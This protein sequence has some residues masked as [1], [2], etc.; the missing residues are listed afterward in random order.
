MVPIVFL[1]TFCVQWFCAAMSSKG[2]VLPFSVPVHCL[3]LPL[4]LVLGRDS[5]LG[6]N[7]GRVLDETSTLRT[8]VTCVKPPTHP[9]L[10][11][12]V[13]F[14]FFNG[15]NLSPDP[16]RPCGSH[17]EIQPSH[18]FVLPMT[19]PLEGGRRLR[20]GP[21]AGRAPLHRALRSLCSQETSLHAA[22]RASSPAS[23]ALLCLAPS[24]LIARHQ[25]GDRSHKNPGERSR[26][27]A[28]ETLVKSSLCSGSFLSARCGHGTRVLRPGSGRGQ[29]EAPAGC[30]G[31]HGR[32]RRW[33][34]WARGS[35]PAHGRSS[36]LHL[37]PWN[38]HAR[39]HTHACTPVLKVHAAKFKGNQTQRVLPC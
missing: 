27:E 30:R 18:H 28:P 2:L 16:L 23:Q 15:F 5:T 38:T 24:P 34:A 12:Q 10:H 32:A 33:C 31:H 6:G 19:H 26:G 4:K 20:V 3:M 8:W 36:L 25:D 29:A 37:A 11:G 14:L 13:P 1:C 22:G 21:G 7:P 17:H 9:P 39:A 35:R